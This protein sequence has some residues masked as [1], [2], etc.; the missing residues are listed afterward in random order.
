MANYFCETYLMISNLLYGTST[1]A[2]PESTCQSSFYDWLCILTI[3]LCVSLTH[4]CDI[5]YFTGMDAFLG[6]FQAFVQY[7]G[8]DSHSGGKKL[9]THLGWGYGCVRLLR[10]FMGVFQEKVQKPATL[11]LSYQGVYLFVLSNTSVKLI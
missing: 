5:I 4:S 8:H 9:D 2:S 6:L 7:T 3:S 10:T 1:L 11:G